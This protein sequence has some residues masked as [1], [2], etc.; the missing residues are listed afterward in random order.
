MRDQDIRNH[1]SVLIDVPRK[2]HVLRLQLL[3]ARRL[4]GDQSHAVISDFLVFV[5]WDLVGSLAGREKDPVGDAAYAD[6]E[7][8][9]SQLGCFN[10]I[11]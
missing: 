2:V 4:F 7:Y 11:I 3:H 9:V 6:E 1:V 10:H 5:I 8:Q